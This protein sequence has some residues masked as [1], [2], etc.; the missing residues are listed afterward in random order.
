MDDDY[1]REKAEENLRNPKNRFL[2]LFCHANEVDDSWG[3]GCSFQTGVF[4]F[5][6]V[7][8]VAIVLD[9]YYIAYDGM[10]A[11]SRSIPA[12]TVMF[13]IKVVS[14]LI[15]LVGIIIVCSTLNRN[16]SGFYPT[17]CYY[18]EILSFLL[19]SIFCVYCVIN[20]F[21]ADFWKIIKLRIISFAFQELD[22]LLF[23]WILFCYMVNTNKQILL[24]NREITQGQ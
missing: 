21:S 15:A 14:D 2:G 4:I 8:G 23:C 7:I 12:F 24:R 9:L 16:T 10:F 17:V 18:I 3:C 22:L 6:T 20:I 19:C 5:S 1:Q 13:G 11:K